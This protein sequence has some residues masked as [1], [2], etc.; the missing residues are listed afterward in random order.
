M[1]NS[2]FIYGY[3]VIVILITAAI[4][5]LND[6]VV[7]GSIFGFLSIRCIISA[8]LRLILGFLSIGLFSLSRY[9]LNLTSFYKINKNV[10]NNKI[11]NK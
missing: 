8:M 3:L 2:V 11:E 4:R 10:I 5:M 7:E 6:F 9:F 1:L